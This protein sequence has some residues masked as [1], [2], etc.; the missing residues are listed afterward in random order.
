[1]FHPSVLYGMGLDIQ[2]QQNKNGNTFSLSNEQMICYE[3]TI[4]FFFKD[5]R[6]FLNCDYK[7][8]KLSEDIGIPVHHISYFINHTY[9]LSYS[10]FINRA[11]IDYLVSIYQYKKYRQLT[12][13]GIAKEAGFNSRSTFIRAFKKYMGVPPSDYFLDQVENNDSSNP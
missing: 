10:N 8:N 3:R 2:K 4:T 5:E 11:R 1:M 12:L 9:G 6:P 7:I 13:E